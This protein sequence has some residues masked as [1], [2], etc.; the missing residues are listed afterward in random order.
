MIFEDLDLKVHDANKIANLMYEVDFR[1]YDYVFKSKEEAIPAIKE[2][3]EKEISKYPDHNM[4]AIIEDNELVGFFYF[5]ESNVSLIK[6]IAFLFKNLNFTNAS[7][8]STVVVLDHFV[9]SNISKGDI[10]LAE[11]AI[12]PDKQGQGLGKKAL[13]LIIENFREKNYKRLV[14]DVDFRND[15]PKALYEKLG[16]VV[17]DKKSVNIGSFERGMYNMDLFL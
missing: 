1:T 3:L 7:R 4:K 9:L 8:F 15:G 6:E 5:S 13:T 2:R 10:Y 17:F 16:F 12:F 11:I 14:L